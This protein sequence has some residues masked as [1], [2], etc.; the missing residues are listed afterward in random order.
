M[1]IQDSTL[2]DCRYT[3]MH[4]NSTQAMLQPNTLRKMSPS[5]P[6]LPSSPT[7]LAAIAKFCGEVILP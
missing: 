4:M 3:T 5:L 1:T 2:V 7:A 6:S